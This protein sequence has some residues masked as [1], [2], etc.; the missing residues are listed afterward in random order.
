MET[1]MSGQPLP[2]NPEII[3]CVN[4]F[5]VIKTLRILFSSAVLATDRIK[6]TQYTNAV[7]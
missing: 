6:T 5:D 1:Q 4:Y 3:N 7:I 2:L